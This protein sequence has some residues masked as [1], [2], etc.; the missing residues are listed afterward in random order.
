[1]FGKQG[2]GFRACVWVLCLGLGYRVWG[3]EGMTGNE[4][5]KKY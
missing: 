3:W 1:M 4:N 2:L 5:G